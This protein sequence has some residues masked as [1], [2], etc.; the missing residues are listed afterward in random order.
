MPVASG[1]ILRSGRGGVGNYKR[2]DSAPLNA[3]DSSSLV[4][5]GMFVRDPK[6]PLL[7]SFAPKSSAQE[8]GQEQGKSHAPGRGDGLYDHR[9]CEQA[10]DEFVAGRK[11]SHELRYSRICPELLVSQIP[12]FE[13]ARRMEE[14]ERDVERALQQEEMMG[15]IILTA[16]QLVASTFFFE[17]ESSSLRETALGYT[18]IGQYSPVPWHS[19]AR[20]TS[21]V[22]LS[23]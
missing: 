12:Q 6:T 3:S 20:E 23:R 2:V 19:A 22:S 9:K 13:D 18:C 21:H 4:Q 11:E 17:T 5:T 14:L 8:K 10:W 7:L 15:S 16:H 1:Q